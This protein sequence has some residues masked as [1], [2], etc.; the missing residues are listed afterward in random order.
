MLIDTLL[1]IAGVASA[2]LL[3]AGLIAGRLNGEWR[4]WPAPP[5]GSLQSFG[6]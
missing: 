6:F 5:V 1:K 3:I 4:I 2:L